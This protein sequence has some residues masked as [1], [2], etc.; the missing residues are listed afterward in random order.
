MVTTELSAQRM[1]S[2]ISSRRI[3]INLVLSANFYFFYWFYL[4][5]KQLKVQ[6]QRDYHPVWHT[7]AL[8][9]TT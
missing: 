7:L 6:T 4:T 3:I 2:I 5:W 8:F 9:L 1:G